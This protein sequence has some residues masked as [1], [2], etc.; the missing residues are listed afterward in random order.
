MDCRQQVVLFVLFQRSCPHHLNHEQRVAFCLAIERV[1]HGWIKLASRDV[2]C[3]GCRLKSSERPK[4]DFCHQAIS[5]QCSQERYQGMPRK[6]LLRAH[7]PDKEQACTR[8]KTQ[9]VMQ[10]FEG[11]VVAPLQV[12]EQEQQR[13]TVGTVACPCPQQ[14][15]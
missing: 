4:R 10:P 7:R 8:L 6:C 2:F 9:Q 12:I 13:L 14:C 11:L 3:Q 15:T 5:L 1:A